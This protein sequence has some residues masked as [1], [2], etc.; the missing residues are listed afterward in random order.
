MELVNGV[1][2]KILTQNSDPEAAFKSIA[3]FLSPLPRLPARNSK[4][5]LVDCMREELLELTLAFD[6][7]L[8]A[9]RFPDVNA[10]AVKIQSSSHDTLK[11]FTFSL[12]RKVMQVLRSS[13]ARS[14]KAS[15]ASERIAGMLGQPASMELLVRLDEELQGES[16]QAPGNVI[17]AFK[18]M[19]TTCTKTVGDGIGSLLVEILADNG[20]YIGGMANHKP[21]ILEDFAQQLDAIGKLG[22]CQKFSEHSIVQVIKFLRSTCDAPLAAL[23]PSVFESNAAG[24]AVVEELAPC[25][26][27]IAAVAKMPAGDP[28]P[29]LL[30]EVGLSVDLRGKVQGAGTK[31]LHQHESKTVFPKIER[32]AAL[33][34]TSN[35][36][37]NSV[38]TDG[39]ATFIT[40]QE[41][42]L[43]A[44]HFSEKRDAIADSEKEHADVQMLMVALGKS[45]FSSGLT[46]VWRLWRLR[47]NYGSFKAKVKELA[48]DFNDVSGATLAAYHSLAESREQMRVVAEAADAQSFCESF[49]ERLKS[50]EVCGLRPFHV[51]RV[52]KECQEALAQSQEGLEIFVGK[53]AGRLTRM[54]NSLAQSVPPYEPFVVAEFKTEVAQ[55][56]LINKQWDHVAHAWVAISKV[57][58]VAIGLN[59]DVV[60]KFQTRHSAVETL[61]TE[62]MA[63]A[64]TFVSV[65]S[66]VTLMLDTLPKTSKANWKT[67]IEGQIE[68]TKGAAIPKNLSDWMQSELKRIKASTKTAATSG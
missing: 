64:K 65:V 49:C 62:A 18:G 31:L 27:A 59:N 40:E 48:G 66:I 17:D 2:L 44:Q 25:I 47:L 28:V 29:S 45:D 54:A 67:M 20:D 8:H 3:A 50:G 51:G 56:E 61:V 21:K 39:D 63:A 68:K 52:L 26:S 38:Q 9:T 42:D 16:F 14:A 11:L 10:I 19:L 58:S 35:D 4:F 53:I 6:M 57:H 60:G 30:D 33:I 43:A 46:L 23:M 34:N 13:C 15:A 24:V 41:F 36:Y 7:S 22:Y 1:L 32:I 37:W 5:K 55:E 12:G